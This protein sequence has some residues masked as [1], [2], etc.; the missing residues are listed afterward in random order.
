MNWRVVAVQQKDASDSDFEALVVS[1]YLDWGCILD[2]W[3]RCG[4]Q[5]W[6]LIL[7]YAI[8]QVMVHTLYWDGEE[9]WK[10][11]FAILGNSLAVQQLGLW[12]FT[13]KGPSSI[14]GR[15]TKIP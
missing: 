3:T 7:V 13:A 6:L 8:R 5:E 4:N 15:G 1:N 10:K 9:F 2:W 14:L 12:A 11:R